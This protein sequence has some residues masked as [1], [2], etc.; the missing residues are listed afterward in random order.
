MN[1]MQEALS[2]AGV[3]AEDFKVN[4]S[5]KFTRFPLIT[6]WRTILS[7]KGQYMDD[8]YKYQ[9]GHRSAPLQQWADKQNR[10]IM[11]FL[12]KNKDRVYVFPADK[13]QK[14]LECWIGYNSTY[15]TFTIRI[16]NLAQMV[17]PF[18]TSTNS[19]AFKLIRAINNTLKLGSMYEMSDLEQLTFLD[20]LNMIP[21]E[22]IPTI[23]RNTF[24][25]HEIIPIESFDP[26]VETNVLVSGNLITA[27]ST[28]LDEIRKQ[29]AEMEEHDHVLSATKIH[30]SVIEL[31]CGFNYIKP[32]DPC[33]A[34]EKKDWLNLVFAKDI[35]GNNKKNKSFFIVI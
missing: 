10:A 15:Q 31:Y 2:K 22:S 32:I 17:C 11:N 23:I 29:L 9:Q 8:T 13:C 5:I 19:Y 3:V 24:E 14:Y 20:I 4:E 26:I 6:K 35:H 18:S 28:N 34:T 21:T 16:N 33:N 7:E 25:T 12:R 27:E 1:T 30:K